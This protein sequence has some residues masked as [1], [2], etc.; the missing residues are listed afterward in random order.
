[1]KGT[2]ALAGLAVAALGPGPQPAEA[3]CSVFHHEPCAPELLYDY[4]LRFTIQSRP[5]D[6]EAAMA[7]KGPL[8]TLNDIAN[9]MRGCWKWPPISEINTGMDLTVLL[10]FKRS[11]EIFGAK[12]TYQSKNVSA[13]ER[14]IYHGV[15]LDAL[16]LC[17]PL[18]VSESLGHAIAGRPML[19]RFHDTRKERKV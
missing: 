13:E 18:P 1:M 12:I 16:K 3:A 2:L 8:N 19:F 9:A 10:S 7:P 17:S 11:G 15:L 4:G 5:M 6:P 14:A